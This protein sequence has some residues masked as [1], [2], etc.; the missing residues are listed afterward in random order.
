M[1]ASHGPEQLTAWLRQLAAAPRRAVVAVD[2]DG[3]VA[4]VVVDPAQ[5]APAD[6]AVQALTDLSARVGTVAVITGRPADSAVQV[7]GLAHVP[8]LV[9][10]GLYGEQHWQGGRLTAP[11]P[12]T[13]LAGAQAELPGVLA[14]VGAAAAGASVE[15]KGSSVAV[16]VRAATDPAAA[17]AALGGPLQALAGRHH[18]VVEPGRLVL[19]L[20]R[21][22]VDKGAALT[23]LVEAAARTSG[24]PSAVLYA[25]DDL[26]DL[27]AF[28]AVAALRRSGVPALSVAAATPEAPQVAAAA[29]VVVD[30]PDGVVA[31]LQA[32]AVELSG[33]ARPGRTAAG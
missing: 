21:P 12:P 1:A 4:P 3:T 26:G 32:I 18:L 28:A 29:D 27:P 11:P 6:G 33:P 5:A 14:S 22:G 20:R 9:V 15:S 10:L 2:Y 23:G 8:G 13:G 19:E 30:G 7:G 24:Q 16:H 25:G 17:L 31:L